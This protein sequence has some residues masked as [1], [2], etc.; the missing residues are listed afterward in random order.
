M[1]RVS[2]QAQLPK[3]GMPGKFDTAVTFDGRMIIVMISGS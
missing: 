1:D 2:V 3:Q